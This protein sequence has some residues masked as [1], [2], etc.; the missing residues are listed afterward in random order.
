MLI[1]GAKLGLFEEMYGGIGSAFLYRNIAKPW[2][3][4]GNFIGLNKE[5]LIRDFHLENMKH[6]QTT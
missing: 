5:N 2:F 1:S 4:A 3:L 6:L